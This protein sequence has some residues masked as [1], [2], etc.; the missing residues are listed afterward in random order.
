MSLRMESTTNCRFC[1]G[2]GSA[3]EELAPLALRALEKNN[4]AAARKWLDRA[5]DKI[6][7]SGSDDPL[8]GSPF[9]YFWTERQDADIPTIRTAA[10]VLLPSKDLKGRVSHGAGPSPAGYEDGHD[11]N[12]MTHG[13]GVCLAAQE[14]W[15][16]MLPLT[17]ELMKASPSFVRAFE[18][19]TMAYA[20]TEAV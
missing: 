20:R 5:R 11:R 8:A 18:L 3:V 10:L 6:H 12:R 15:V 1:R 16:E 4:P 14:H 13:H 9:P 7:V 2:A 19:A 17:Q